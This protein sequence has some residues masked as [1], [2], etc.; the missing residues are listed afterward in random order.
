MSAAGNEEVIHSC[1]PAAK[2]AVRPWSEAPH[3]GA[4]MAV[5]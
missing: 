5:R 2:S 3:F 4:G 1:P